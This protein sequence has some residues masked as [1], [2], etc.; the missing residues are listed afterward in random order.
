M[1]ASR[2][3]RW[4]RR[5]WRGARGRYFC[6]NSL[7]SNE[8]SAARVRHVD[9]MDDA[10]IKRLRRAIHRSYGSSPHKKKVWLALLEMQVAREQRACADAE[11]VGAAGGCGAFGSAAG[12]VIL[13]SAAVRRARLSS[14]R[15]RRSQNLTG[16]CSDRFE[17]YLAERCYRAW[18]WQFQTRGL[19]SVHRL[20]RTRQR[21]WQYSRSRAIS[22]QRVP[23]CV[24][25]IAPR[26]SPP[27]RS[28][29]SRLY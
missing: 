22:W 15:V 3:G 17:S 1:S 20:Q 23:E 9:V 27:A 12:V 24:H 21:D 8:A 13:M 28:C 16:A 7:D 18:D 5:R 11:E 10:E 25:R 6:T 19:P 29:S 14:P 4:W 2:R 26:I